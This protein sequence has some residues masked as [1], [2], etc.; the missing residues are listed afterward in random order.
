MEKKELHY[1]IAK[2]IAESDSIGE[3]WNGYCEDYTKEQFEREMTEPYRSYASVSKKI[4]DLLP[5]LSFN[6]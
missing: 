1:Q 5:P 4:M 3:G 2:I 6:S